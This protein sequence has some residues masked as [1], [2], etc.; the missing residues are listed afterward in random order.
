MQGLLIFIEMRRFET[1]QRHVVGDRHLS[2]PSSASDDD[3]LLY[4]IFSSSSSS[5]PSSVSVGKVVVAVSRP[6]APELVPFGV[7]A[8][9]QFD[10]ENVLETLQWMLK[11]HLLGQDMFL[12]SSPGPLARWTAFKWCELL[13]RECRVV[14]VTPDTTES[15]LKQRREIRGR[16]LVFVDSPA[17]EA[18]KRGLVLVVE[19]LDLAER[20]VATV[21][22]NLL[23]NREMQLEDGTFLTARYDSLTPA[24]RSKNNFVRVDPRFRV[25]VAG[26]PTPRYAGNPLDPPLRSRFQYRTLAP[27]SAVAQLAELRG[28]F[29]NAD[30]NTL[31]GLVSFALSISATP[32]APSLPYDAT[33][34]VAFLLERHPQ[35]VVAKLLQQAFP[36]RFMALEEP[37]VAA[38]EAGLKWLHWSD[39]N[40]P[41]E[42]VAI[43]NGIAVG[44]DG[45]RI[46]VGGSVITESLPAEAPLFAMA[47]DVMEWKKPVLLIGERGSGKTFL[48]RNLS[49]L[50]DHKVVVMQLYEDLAARDLLQR[51][52]TDDRGDTIWHDS[53]LILAARRGYCCVLDGLD[54]LRPGVLASVQRLLQ[55]GE[56]ELPDGSRLVSA[57]RFSILQKK[58]SSERLLHIAPVHPDFRVLATGQ[59][60]TKKKPWLNALVLSMFKVHVLEG[61]T[62]PQR[63]QRLLLGAGANPACIS[64]LQRLNASLAALGDATLPPLSLRQLLRLAHTSADRLREGVLSCFLAPFLPLAAKTQLEAICSEVGLLVPLKQARWLEIV[65]HGSDRVNIGRVSGVVRQDSNSALVPKVSFFPVQA[66]LVLLEAILEDWNAGEHLLLIGNQGVGKNVLTDKLLELL[67]QVEKIIL[68]FKT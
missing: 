55:E 1:I 3:G 57:V 4:D 56:I 36:F 41:V 31:R 30:A 25:I 63:I 23:E 26:I 34:Y 19:G 10:S 8:Q 45:V 12:L 52:S 5:F 24:E 40:G 61:S 15:D 27:L 65:Q 58:C 2:L 67:G 35:A 21:L 46:S 18:A 51:R 16:S 54:Q 62:S 59:S 32:T 9:L 47:I 7:A 11:K 37:V 22:N 38:V 66:H 39:E 42:L 33:D 14:T 13:S 17:V 20:G 29:P 60:A 48:L 50:L 68:F 28:K 64:V 44:S 43:E 53:E 49:S 6:E